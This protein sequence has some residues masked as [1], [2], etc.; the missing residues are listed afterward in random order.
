LSQRESKGRS[1]F[2]NQEAVNPDIGKA[3]P[4]SEKIISFF[5]KKKLFSKQKTGHCFF[6]DDPRFRIGKDN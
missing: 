3:Y 6:V 2:V 1:I 5:L 4:L